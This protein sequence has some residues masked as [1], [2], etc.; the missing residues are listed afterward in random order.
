MRHEEID[1]HSLDAT[2]FSSWRNHRHFRRHHRRRCRLLLCCCRFN[3][4]SLLLFF[5]VFS[6]FF[7]IAFRRLP[8]SLISSVHKIRD[9]KERKRILVVTIFPIA[10]TTI[11]HREFVLL[12]LLFVRSFVLSLMVKLLR[13]GSSCVT[14][15]ALA[16]TWKA[17]L[18][19]QSVQPNTQNSLVSGTKLRQRK[20]RGTRRKTVNGQNGNVHE[21]LWTSK[22]R[23][24]QRRRTREKRQ[25]FYQSPVQQTYTLRTHLVAKQNKILIMLDVVFVLGEKWERR[26]DRND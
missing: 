11:Y 12:F 9:E 7:S 18:K 14:H 13:C 20:K 21:L 8:S 25:N 23:W 2:S 10:S 16:H 6:F 3:S 1:T 15:N 17:V 26:C 24:Q 19:R 22:W 5:S 4:I